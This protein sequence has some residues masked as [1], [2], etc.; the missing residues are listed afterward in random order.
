MQ[1]HPV[2]YRLVFGAAMHPLH[3]C[4]EPAIRLHA[5]SPAS[6][7]SSCAARALRLLLPKKML[8]SV[9]ALFWMAQHM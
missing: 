8:R 9:L 6:L 4:S 7:L 5:G 1:E 3:K 2:M